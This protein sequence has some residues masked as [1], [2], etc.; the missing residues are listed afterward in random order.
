LP[1][2]RER[3]RRDRRVELHAVVREHLVGALHRADRRFQ[4][5]AARVAEALAGH[6]VRLLADHALAAHLLHLAVRIGDEPV[7]A[8]QFRRHG[9]AI[10]DRDRVGKT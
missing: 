7:A 9:A 8:Q 1:G 5:G 6:Q 2:Y 3:E 10:A 4:Y